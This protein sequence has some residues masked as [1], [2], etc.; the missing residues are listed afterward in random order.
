MTPS[1]DENMK[2]L[3]R[4]VF[5]KYPNLMN[6][7]PDWWPEII[8]S[9]FKTLSSLL[10]MVTNT[11]SATMNDTTKRRME[12]LI[13]ILEQYK[14]DSTFIYDMRNVVSEAW[15]YRLEAD[16][17]Y[18]EAE[19]LRTKLQILDDKIKRGGASIFFI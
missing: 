6:M 10:V 7:H 18:K 16:S 5:V 14:L 13:G 3:L 17:L 1:L 4:K 11:T 9:C 12:L 19:E 15:K 8:E 2:T